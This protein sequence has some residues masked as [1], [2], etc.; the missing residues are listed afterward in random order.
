MEVLKEIITYEVAAIPADMTR[1]F[2]VN[3][4]KRLPQCIDNTLMWNVI[5]Y[6]A[7]EYIL[8]G[9]VVISFEISP[10]FVLHPVLNCSIEG[11]SL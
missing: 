8:H 9:S 5:E 10:F 2:M 4:R 1:K 3:F 7:P 11:G 6:T